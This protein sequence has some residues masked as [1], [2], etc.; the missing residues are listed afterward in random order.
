M[1]YEGDPLQFWVFMRTFENSVAKSSLSDGA[2]LTRLLQY[3]KGLAGRVIQHCTVMDPKDGY[4]NTISLLKERFG[5]N[6][7]IA[8]AWIN[9]VTGEG[10]IAS[11]DKR[12]IREFADDLKICHQTL[13]AMGHLSEVNTQKVILSIVE[14]LPGFVRNRWI[15]EVRLIRKKKDRVP[16][17]VD[18]VEFVKDIV[19]EICD[20]V[21]GKLSYNRKEGNSS[22]NKSGSTRPRNKGSNFSVTTDVVAQGSCLKCK[23]ESRTLFECTEFK[24]MGARDRL[25]F[26]RDK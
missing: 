15:R 16:N 18:L 22:S 5:S 23:K 19:D 8:D 4:C 9:K 26:A 1:I 13:D 11:H 14:C 20:P 7:I 2:K 17:F 12:G 25:S 6:Y 3:C 21:Y 10:A 24:G